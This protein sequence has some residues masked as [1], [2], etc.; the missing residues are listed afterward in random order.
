MLPVD[1]L[2]ER[3]VLEVGDA[4]EAQAAVPG[5]E[6]LLDEVLGVFR[7]VRHTGGELETLLKT[8]TET[9]GF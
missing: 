2:E 8:Q 1:A 3:V 5:A 6:E 9:L 7:D 4:V